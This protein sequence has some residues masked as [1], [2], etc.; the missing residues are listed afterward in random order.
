MVQLLG[1]VV[2]T[3]LDPAGGAG[4]DEGKDSASSD[5]VYELRSLFHDGEVGSGVGIEY[6]VKAEHLES[7]HHLSGYVGSDG[8]SE[9]FAKGCTDSRCRLYNYVFSCLES[10]VNFADFGFFH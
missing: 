2:L 10:S 5:S 4:G 3:E 8:I 1:E 9:F 6:L 7:G